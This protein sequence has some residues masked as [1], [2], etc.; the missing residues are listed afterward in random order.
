MTIME[1][2]A[3]DYVEWS[4]HGLAL[5][6]D[7]NTTKN[8]R[9]AVEFRPLNI[10]DDTIVLGHNRV[11][12]ASLLRLADMTQWKYHMFTNTYERLNG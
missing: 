6:I 1:F 11:W 4:A 9:P 2:K 3:G 7:A 8:G 5:V 10:G 12:R